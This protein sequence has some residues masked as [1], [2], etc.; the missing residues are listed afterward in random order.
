MPKI[1]IDHNITIDEALE[2][3]DINMDD[4]AKKQGKEDWNGM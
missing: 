2:I 3:V 1:L 4:F